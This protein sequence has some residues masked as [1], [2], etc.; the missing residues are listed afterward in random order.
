MTDRFGASIAMQVSCFQQ[1]FS[2]CWLAPIWMGKGMNHSNPQV[3]PA[4]SPAPR[5]ARLSVWLPGG[6]M[7]VCAYLHRFGG[8]KA[9]AHPVQVALGFAVIA[10]ALGGFACGI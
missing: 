1:Y 9:L 2:R 4:S 5:L 8:A 6:I 7:L 10:A 3:E